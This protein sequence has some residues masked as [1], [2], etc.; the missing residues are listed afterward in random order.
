MIGQQNQF[1][2]Y[3]LISVH[4]MWGPNVYSKPENNLI[5]GSSIKISQQT[6]QCLDFLYLNLKTNGS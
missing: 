5:T 6:A 3:S 4:T 2:N 1:Q